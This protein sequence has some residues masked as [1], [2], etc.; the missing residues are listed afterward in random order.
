MRIVAIFLLVASALALGAFIVWG[1]HP[2]GPTDRALA[3]LQSDSQVTVSQGN[4]IS[5][6][7]AGNQPT[8]GLIFYP[9]GHVD[10]RSYA[11]LAH[12]LAARGYYVAILPMPLNLAVFGVERANAAIAA[13]PEIG[14]WAVGGHSLGGVVAAQFAGRHL[15][16]IRGLALLAAYPAGDLAATDL[17]GLQVYGSQDRV[18]NM[19]RVESAARLLPPATF[20]QV[21]QGGNHAQFGDYGPQPGDGEASLSVNAQQAEVVDELDR[22]LRALDAH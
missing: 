7:P 9:G 12:Q 1:L 8:S 17:R 21:I 13:H 15:D 22:L 3:A 4:W 10:Y 2:L 5:F 16:E 20:L 11:P 6:Q 14:H 19:D 18:L